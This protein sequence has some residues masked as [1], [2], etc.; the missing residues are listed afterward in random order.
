MYEL[1]LEYGTFP[2]SLVSDES[3]DLHAVPDFLSEDADLVQRLTEMNELFHSLIV[4]IEGSLD[5]IGRET[6][7]KIQELH[8]LFDE[9]AAITKKNTAMSASKP[10]IWT[11]TIEPV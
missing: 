9:L 11:N 3:A 6:P 1:C 5:Y 2:I 8:R 10:F 4:E 7:E